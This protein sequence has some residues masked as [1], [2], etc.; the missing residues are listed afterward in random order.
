MNIS[1]RSKSGD[2]G[3]SP[4]V[5]SVFYHRKI[6]KYMKKWIK[7]IDADIRNYVQLKEQGKF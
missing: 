7:K 6:S 2:T 1:E 4:S 3:G 5:Q